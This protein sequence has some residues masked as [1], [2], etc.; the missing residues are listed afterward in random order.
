MRGDI[1]HLPGEAPGK[2]FLNGEVPGLNV[3]PL[4]LLGIT[5]EAY[6]T[7]N[8]DNAITR[9]RSRDRRYTLRQRGDWKETVGRLGCE[10]DQDGVVR[11]HKLQALVGI[12]GD[13]IAGANHPGVPRPVGDPQT[14]SEELFTNGGA[15]IVGN[16]SHTAKL[17]FVGGG[18]VEFNAPVVACW[19]GKIL[20]TQAIVERQFGGDIPPITGV[21]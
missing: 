8:V 20:P 2:F 10:S 16:I 11:P 4:E 3:A 21:K 9:V 12:N 15:A 1:A 5:R 18:V 19:G 14:G 6:A 7:G 13:A 17:N